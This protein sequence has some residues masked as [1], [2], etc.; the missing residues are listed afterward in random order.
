[1]KIGNL[2]QSKAPVPDFF[3]N[4]HPRDIETFHISKNK[5]YYRE[6]DLIHMTTDIN[7]NN[8][9]RN[10]MRR[11]EDFNKTRYIPPYHSKQPFLPNSSTKSP[12]ESANDYNTMMQF[13]KTTD[14]LNNANPELREEIK[15]NV[16]TLLERINSN[17]DL[18][19]WSD[20]NLSTTKRIFQS[21][22]AFV[23]NEKSEKAYGSPNEQIFARTLRG[24]INTLTSVHPETKM[25]VLTNKH[26]L[27]LLND[28]K[29]HT[30]ACDMFNEEEAKYTQEEK[31]FIQDN[32]FV[33]KKFNSSTFYQGFPSPTR[34]EFSKKVAKKKKAKK[35]P[36]FPNEPKYNF[37]AKEL[38]NINDQMFSRPLHS[39]KFK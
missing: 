12:K 38:F 8:N 15:T 37:D 32:E 1:M 7:L 26:I 31:M 39:D 6:S 23:T 17:Y 24:K 16:D 34:M 25:K 35:P 19:K 21:K 5:R 2:S 9:H 22:N 14:Y 13:L 28:R 11:S 33:Y 36:M 27:P 30:T 3:L 18:K 20:F 29:A 10:N 4:K